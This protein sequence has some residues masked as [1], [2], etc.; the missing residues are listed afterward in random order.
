[1]INTASNPQWQP[2]NGQHFAIWHDPFAKPSYLFALVA[3][4]LAV[5]RDTFTT[6]SG[7]EVAI[8]FY[9]RAEDAGKVA[10]AMQSLKH[11]M[12]WDET[13]FG[14]EYDLDVFMVVAVGDFNMARWKTKA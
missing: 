3:G 13:R 4:D 6:Q 9:T 1:M 11:A 12:R 8:R 7:R 14:L 2:E 10:H 5:N